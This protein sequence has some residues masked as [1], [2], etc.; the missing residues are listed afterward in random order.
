MGF[1]DFDKHYAQ[2]QQSGLFDDFETGKTS[3]DEFIK[4]LRKYLP[5]TVEDY[6]IVA[7][8]NALLL[9]W[10]KERIELLTNLK[11]KYKMFLFSNTNAIHKAHFDQT[12]T[13]QTGLQT[14]DTLFEKAYY[15]HLFGKRKPHPESFEALLRENDL[16]AEQTLFIDDSIQHIEG[17]RKAGLEVIH[18]TNETIFDLEF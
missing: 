17:A 13:E 8:W 7:A 2:A 18:L 14:L 3:P 5:D 16:K 11:S 4:A 1:V 10:H 6:E 15:S 12:L 9:P